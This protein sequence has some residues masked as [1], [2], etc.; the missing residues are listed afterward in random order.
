[1]TQP[2]DP[3]KQ[4]LQDDEIALARVLRALPAGEPPP[5]LDAAILAAATDA[6]AAAPGDRPRARKPRRVLPWLL[7]QPPLPLLLLLLH[8]WRLL[9]LRLRGKLRLL[10]PIQLAV[11]KLLQRLLSLLW[12]GWRGGCR[13]RLEGTGRVA[14]PR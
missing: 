2:Q 1:M 4:P 5:R 9:L 12:L 8:R 11:Q 7:W 13:Q 14:G 10:L 6:V 3:R